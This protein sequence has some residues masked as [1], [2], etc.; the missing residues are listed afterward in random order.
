[1][2]WT[3]FQTYNDAPD[4][5]FEILCN[6]LFENWCKEN[7]SEE[8]T[9]FQVVNGAGGDGGVESY[10]V[11]SDG[12]TIGLQAKWFP[13]SI[14]SN[15]MGQ[16][17][18]SLETALRIRPQIS[19]YIVC[20]PRDLAS[21]TAKGTNTED[22]R[23]KDMISSILTTYPN[24]TIELWNETR[25]TQ[26]LQKDCSSGIF[27][28]WFERAEISEE[29]IRFSFAKSKRSWLSMKYV[30]ELNTFGKIHRYISAYL[31]NVDQWQKLSKS[32][33]EISTLC[34]DFCSASNELIGVCCE[35]DPNIVA[36]LRQSKFQIQTMQ[37][38]VEK[39]E[40]WLGDTSPVNFKFDEHAFR[41]NFNDIKMR[42][43]ESKEEYSYYFHFSAVIKVLELFERIQIQSIL[44]QINF[45]N[46]CRS[47]IFL[48][49]PGTGKTHGVAA[50]TERLL[51]E[52]Y[53]IPILIQARDIPATASWKDILISN[54]GLSDVWSEEEVWQGLSSF[55]N[56]KRFHAL[57]ALG[58]TTVLPKVIIIIDGIDESSLY[59]KWIER[60]QETGTITQSYPLLRFC[61]MSRPYVFKGK[62]TGARAINISVN[63]DV[64]TYKLFDSYIKAYH[65]DVSCTGWV[66]YA[67]TTPLALKLFCELNE[68]KPI[69]YHSGADVS[70]AA[71]L[72]EKINM[73]EK[74]Y[75]KQTASITVV[76]QYIYRAILQLTYLF[77]QEFR[78]E[79]KQT[80]DI[81]TQ[82]LSI[83]TVQSRGLLE[84]LANYGILR[85][86]C[87]HQSG[88]LAL[89]TYFYYPGIQGYFDY[90]SALMLIDKYK[91]P[92]NIDFGN[93]KNIPQNA[94]YVLAIVSAQRFSYI[95]TK[96][97]SINAAISNSFKKDLTLFALRHMN[98]TE[99]EQ[100][101]QG[102]IK[103]MEISADT[104]L[105]ITN[106]IVLPL[107]R[108]PHHP[109]GVSLLNEL[110]SR[111]ERPAQRDILW[112]MPSGLKGSEKEKWYSSSQLAIGDEAYA[113]TDTDTAE[114]LPVIYAWA[115]SSVDN[116]KRKVCRIALLQWALHVPGEFYALFLSFS[117]VNDPQ[118]K[119]D[120]Y[121]ILMSLL[122]EED[123]PGLLQAT[124]NWLMENVLAADKIKDIC[125]IAIRHY[126]TSIVRK[127]QSLGIVDSETASMYLP[128]Y[129]PASNCINLSQEALA[130]T[131]MGGYKGITYDLGR[132]VLIDHITSVLPDHGEG[133]AQQY[134]RLI[135]NISVN[136]P[137][138]A[139]ISSS[140]FILSAAYEFIIMCGWNEKEFLDYDTKRKNVYGADAAIS[141]SYSPQTHGSQS[142]IMTICEKYV[143]Q[144]RNYI[145]GFLADHLMYIDDNGTSYI[146][147]YGLLDDFLI[148]AL[149]IGQVD[150]KSVKEL[151]PWHIPEKSSVI[152]SSKPNSQE[153]V[154]TAIRTTPNITWGEWVQIDNSS[155][156][157]P[158]DE[159][160]L[161]VLTGFSCFESSSGVETNLYINTILISEN[162]LNSF[163]DAMSKTTGMS[164]RVTNPPDWKG[165]VQAGCYITPKEICW[166]PW[167]KRCDSWNVDQFPAMKIN[168]TVDQC[169][170]NFLEYGDVVYDLPA[171]PIREFLKITNT[172]GYEFYGEDKQIKAINV[173]AGENWRTQQSQLLINH[174]LL[175]VVQTGGKVLVWIM[176]EQRVVNA[177]GRERFGD[178]YEEK[179]YSY[180]GF[181]KDSKF[182]VIQ[183]PQKKNEEVD[184]A[185]IYKRILAMYEGN[186]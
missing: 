13:D 71:L 102:L 185:D 129:R 112:S 111:F 130:G 101:R 145:S 128:P 68:G 43:K 23:W 67:L 54:L 22:K 125:D 51:D 21:L 48:G 30:P 87:E 108:E 163:I 142:P 126:A 122:F 141:R 86:Y 79:R 19:F 1:M 50:E 106:N 46:D 6:Q 91:T 133:V 170:Y 147:D 82:T 7:Y 109:L 148:P 62:D 2:N 94:Y 16:I 113:L 110:L 143:W 167:K 49:E 123:L 61:F 179:D 168:S 118:I 182:V 18:R 127:A 136:R 47:V 152:N 80:I 88:L 40:L 153:D 26:E 178:F 37:H 5:A 144:A 165:S 96:N 84:Y 60:V 149:E 114:G 55:A 138:F 27:K 156:Q 117:S 24:L 78:L 162:D 58:H 120:L 137:E 28:F 124:A 3:N 100:Y 14:S 74:E 41:I 75:C 25:L 180:I 115:L 183:I 15:Q 169:T 99:A 73:L 174:S 65:V 103:F 69:A 134:E 33:S 32:F 116:A 8:L 72:K 89:D 20:I 53:H 186:Q 93:C 157:Y 85:L 155:H 76:D 95:I 38:E 66:K 83:D 140:Q 175:D 45:A 181:Y 31:G 164:N 151:Y 63:G 81:I 52:G 90:A 29:S 9:S 98:A 135:E 171:A 42:L 107:S 121:S 36:M 172:N 44:N 177:K 173:S 176:R 70:I 35:S 146:C 92:Q 166:M 104:L 39:I 119:S 77:S 56:R 11:L 184:L 154:V 161:I 64:P 159:D 132:Y 160:K 4:K 158:V 97:T 59:D 34:N 105:T 10:A 131:Y 57:G 12:E 17:K 139:G 150:P